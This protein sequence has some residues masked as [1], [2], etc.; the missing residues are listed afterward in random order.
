MSVV[1]R[2]ADAEARQR[3]EHTRGGPTPRVVKRTPAW[4][5]AALAAVALTSAC[6]RAVVFIT[7]EGNI[8]FGPRGAERGGPGPGG[9]VTDQE[10]GPPTPHIARSA[11]ETWRP[12]PLGILPPSSVLRNTS[13]PQRV[14]A[15][16]LGVEL[17]GSDRLVPAW[18]GDTYVRVDLAAGTPRPAPPARDLAVLLDVR[19]PNALPRARRIAGALFE[20]LRDRDRGALVSTEARGRALVPLLGRGAMPLLVERTR[21]YQAPAG[22]DDLAGALARALETMRRSEREGPGNDGRIRRLVLLTASGE[23]LD[24][25]VIARIEALSAE[26]VELVVVP[27]SEGAARRFESL[28]QRTGALVLPELADD[29]GQER[30]AIEELSSLPEGEIAARN[31]SLVVDSVPGP[32]HLIEVAGATPTWTPGG[33]EVPLGDVRDGD[34]RTLVLRALVPP[35]RSEGRFELFV[36]VRYEDEQG[37]HEVHRRFTATYTNQPR[38][39]ADSR[40]GDVLQ[41]V[42][43]LNTLS[44]VQAAIARGDLLTLGALRDAASLQGRALRDYADANRDD[45]MAGQSA[46]LLGLLGEHTLAHGAGG[47]PEGSRTH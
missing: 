45:A 18:G 21:E 28:G 39:W 19:E 46:L 35:W 37:P 12:P 31:V 10:H 38:E 36:R 11:M 27:L 26:G 17:R 4:V 33:G 5:S 2:I 29:Y 40:A 42:S 14:T 22:Q 44:H 23:L 30:G 24:A 8:A 13:Q 6:G 32:A 9:V 3:S 41:Y 1:K 43:L 47:G 25:E 16:S 20:T 7:P 15:G 34:R